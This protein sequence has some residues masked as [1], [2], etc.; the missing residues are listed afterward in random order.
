MG[1]SSAPA[2]ATLPPVPA[3]VGLGLRWGFLDEVL[4]SVR[5]EAPP[6][7]VDFFEISPENYMRRGGYIPTAL[8]EVRAAYPILSHGLTMSVGGTDPLNADYL[9]ELA[10]FLPSVGAPFHSDHLCFGGSGGRL[11]HDLLPLPF[12]EEA[13][14][15]VVERAARVKDAIG[16]PFA[17]ENISYYVR[18]GAADMTES[19]FLRAVV[20]EADVDLL[21]DVNNVFVNSKNF[22]FDAWAFLESLPLERVVQIHVAGHE[23]R[24]EHGRIIDTHGADADDGVLTLLERVI[25]RIGPVPVLIE[26]DTNIPAFDALLGEVARVRAAYDRGLSRRAA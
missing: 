25:Q 19:A 15:N 9:R 11:V 2:K 26:R 20:E 4:A 6:L 21:L 23:M 5:S 22:D 13:V 3:G 17:V 16:L 14:A 12:I 18:P 10:A 7:P 1:K 8:E 24:P